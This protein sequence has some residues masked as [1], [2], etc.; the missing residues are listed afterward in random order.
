MDARLDCVLGW[1]CTLPLRAPFVTPIRP[2]LPP[3]EPK[4][5]AGERGRRTGIG[6]P[7]AWTDRASVRAGV[8]P[9]GGVA[10]PPRPPEGASKSQRMEGPTMSRVAGLARSRPRGPT[11]IGTQA[12]PSPWGPGPIRI[13]AFSASVNASIFTRRPQRGVAWEEGTRHR[14]PPAGGFPAW[15][16]SWVGEAAGVRAVNTSAQAKSS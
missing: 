7:V 4:E 16:L 1:A 5:R 11:A 15:A 6:T 8:S 9:A 13:D 2:R 10:P 12:L 14:P 3:K